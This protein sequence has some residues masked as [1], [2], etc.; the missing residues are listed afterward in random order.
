MKA[1]GKHRLTLKQIRDFLLSRD[2][3]ALHRE[4]RQKRRTFVKVLSSAPGL[5]MQMD[6]FYVSREHKSSNY[7]KSA[8]LLLIDVCTRKAYALPLINHRAINVVDVLKLLLKKLPFKPASLYCDRES[9]YVSSRMKDFL[10]EKNVEVFYPGNDLTKASICERAG[11]TLKGLLFKHMR[12]AK[13]KRWVTSLQSAVQ[14]YNS[15]PHSALD[16]LSP[17][18]ALKLGPAEVWRRAHFNPDRRKKRPAPAEEARRPA[19]KKSTVRPFAFDVGDAVKIAI[20]KSLIRK[21]YRNPSYTAENF[22]VTERERRQN[23]NF[24]FLQDERGEEIVG[25]F[26]A[27]ELLKI[28]AQ[29]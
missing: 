6:S 26:T 28:P 4:S 3:Y 17:N 9:A 25:Y 29:N 22:R 13:T 2:D 14:N 15:R 1:E 24:Y 8:F 12:A 27:G 16:G 19:F 20:K 18:E 23:V 21:G 11:R 7:G 5:Y 10:K